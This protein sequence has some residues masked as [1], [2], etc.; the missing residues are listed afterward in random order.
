MMQ[1]LQPTI[2]IFVD[3][4]VLVECKYY[5]IT[6]NQV[7]LDNLILHTGTCITWKICQILLRREILGFDKIGKFFVDNQCYVSS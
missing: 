1:F 4:S 2:C 7:D 3:S 6:E 5:Q